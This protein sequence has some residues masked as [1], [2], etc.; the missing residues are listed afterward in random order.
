MGANVDLPG[1]F[2]GDLNIFGDL[3]SGDKSV[4]FIHHYAGMS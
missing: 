2:R 3:I 1:A 4:K